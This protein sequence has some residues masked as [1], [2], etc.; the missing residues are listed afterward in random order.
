KKG[1]LVTARLSTQRA[2]ALVFL[3]TAAAT[4]AGQVLDADLRRAR[5]DG[6]WLTHGGDYAET[7]FS[8]LDAIDRDTVARLGLAWS[9]EVGA[10]NGRVEGTPLVVDGVLYGTTTWSVAFAIDLNTQALKWRYD[11]QVPRQ[12]GPRVCCGP[13]NRG[14]AFYDGKVY[15]ATLDG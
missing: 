1:A 6:E 10:P 4:A 11:P 7:R 13:V 8:T 9:V 5:A 2:L 15:V 3:A 12:G 14:P